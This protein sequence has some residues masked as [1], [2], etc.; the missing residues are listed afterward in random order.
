MLSVMNFILA[1]DRIAAGTDLNPCQCIIVDIV[2]FDQTTTFAKNVNTALMA[3]IYF[4]FPE[5]RKNFS[6]FCL[7]FSHSNHAQT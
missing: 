7:F 3:G 2:T 1:N 6:M 5:K 4:I